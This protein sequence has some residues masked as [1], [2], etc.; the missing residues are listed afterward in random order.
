M[1]CSINWSIKKGKEEKLRKGIKT[2]FLVNANKTVRASYYYDNDAP[3]EF[4]YLVC[5]T[6][7]TVNYYLASLLEQ[8]AIYYSIFLIKFAPTSE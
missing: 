7:H 1:I 2:N 3:F 6:H 8:T 4:K 5:T